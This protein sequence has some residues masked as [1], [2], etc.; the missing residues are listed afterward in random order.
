MNKQRY[1]VGDILVNT[2][3][4]EEFHYLVFSVVDTGHKDD[5]HYEFL[6]LDN[7]W[8]ER[9]YCTYVDR[10]DVWQKAA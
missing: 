10:S 5:S 3:E 9:W 6:S 2:G 4:V 7:D 8:T 1:V